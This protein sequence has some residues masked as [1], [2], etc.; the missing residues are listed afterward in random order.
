VISPRDS[1]AIAASIIP[2]EGTSR[3]AA[4]PLNSG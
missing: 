2:I 3:I 4:L 1:M